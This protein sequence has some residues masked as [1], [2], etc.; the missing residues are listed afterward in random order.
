MPLRVSCA[1]VSVSSTPKI[2]KSSF[3]GSGVLEIDSVDA[4]E[5][6]RRHLAILV[7]EHPHAT[8]HDRVGLRIERVGADGGRISAVDADDGEV[9]LQGLVELRAVVDVA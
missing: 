5:R 8:L 6:Q 4:E 2:K 3:E 9:V 1:T 7:L